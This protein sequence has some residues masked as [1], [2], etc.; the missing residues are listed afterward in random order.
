MDMSVFPM[1]LSGHIASSSSPT[2]QQQSS[3]ASF[4]SFSHPSNYFLA[5]TPGYGAVPYTTS[6]W[7]GTS[8]LPLSNYSSLNGATSTTSSQNQSSQQSPTQSPPPPPSQVM[9]DPSL[10]LNM[11]G[12]SSSPPPQYQT[13]YISHA[14]HV[15]QRPQYTAYQHSPQPSALSI[16][17]SF[18][19][20]TPSHFQQIH[21]QP[22]L[23]Q[24]QHSPQASISPYVLHSPPLS[25][26]S[27]SPPISTASFYAQ[28]QQPQPPPPPPQP[29]GPTPEQLKEKF[30]AGL[31]PLLQSNSFSGAGAV[32]RLTGHIEDYGILKVDVP[33]RLDILSKIRDNAG[34]HYFRAWAENSLA[35]LIT[36]RWL[37]DSVAE[38]KSEA[39]QTTMPLL[40]VLDRLPMTIDCLKE[41][42]IGKE[43]K[44]VSKS[45]S[46]NS[47]I[48]DMASNIASKWRALLPLGP[49]QTPA[50]TKASE[51]TD[52]KSK[53]RKAE[54]PP[55]VVKG[56]PATK[57]GTVTTVASTS[58]AT[59]ATIVAK[60]P[61]AKAPAVKDA[62]TDISFFSAAKPKP[63][64]PDFKKAPF[65]VK[66]E[67][68]LNVAQP[69]SYN[70]F[71][72]IV[73]SLKPR[74]ESP[75]TATPPPLTTINGPTASVE[76]K[77]LSKKK[78]VT[79]APDG[80]LELIKVIE[81]AVYDDDPADGMHGAHSV[82]ELERG[83]GA[84]LIAHLFE[85]QI[86]W[87]EPLIIEIPPEIEVPER[88]K[89]SIEKVAQDE[90]EQNALGAL[91]ITEAQIPETAGEPTSALPDDQI[92]TQAKP[93]LVGQD[94][95]ALFWSGVPPPAAMASS[96]A[97][98]V[99]QLTA[100]GLPDVIMSDANPPPAFDPSVLANIRPE[101]LQ[102]L[103]QQAQAL[104]GVTPPYPLGPSPPTG[105][106]IN[107]DQ[108][109][110]APPFQ[111]YDR[112]YEE[113]D[114]PWGREEGA[115]A[116]EGGRDLVLSFSREGVDMETGVI[117]ATSQPRRRT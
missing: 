45:S 82:R 20:T 96:V 10:T 102:Q 110:N 84:A 68:D 85:E 13:A 71:E 15:Q 40:H 17:P 19:H 14:S 113:K 98:L 56:Q 5:S 76:L 29:S 75:A 39:A 52:A 57:K 9:I 67:P 46:S 90:R 25:N 101:A 94:M 103:V 44:R 42:G 49:L 73:K 24:T 22:S 4:Y 66:K 32:Q 83:E 11:N 55:S 107:G 111:E 116:S 109:W 3:P 54:E 60:K 65:T 33:T 80:Q 1:D 108:D 28:P 87:S 41:S 89:D 93:M 99:G 6:S 77:K 21:R 35:M 97:E 18:V 63:K 36:K 69:S 37:T 115:M 74:K 7:P 105:P 64:L 12:S 114:R 79:W 95:E 51:D 106:R 31:K 8:T 86:D 61:L 62:K 16:N 70:P 92:D 30:L 72:E 38:D 117:S 48:R 91:Y 81:R 23:Q 47:A 78:S 58:K 27:S 34:N 59:T 43:V 88:G 112:G 53:K 50:S 26:A 100:G 2:L 104:Q